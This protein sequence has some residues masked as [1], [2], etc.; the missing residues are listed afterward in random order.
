MAIDLYDAKGRL[1]TDDVPHEAQNLLIKINQ[2]IDSDVTSY[3]Y[4][5]T[6]NYL[7]IFI[8]FS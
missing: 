8:D 6:T 5:T 7:H 2:S 3:S 1:Y 4:F